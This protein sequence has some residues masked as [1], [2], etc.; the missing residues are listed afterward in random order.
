MGIFDRVGIRGLVPYDPGTEMGDAAS[1]VTPVEGVTPIGKRP[2]WLT[3]G[4]GAIPPGLEF[5]SQPTSLPYRPHAATALT[6]LAQGFLGVMSKANEAKIA[7]DERQQMHEE[8][9]TSARLQERSIIASETD[10]AR[11]AKIEEDRNNAIVRK[12]VID[13]VRETPGLSDFAARTGANVTGLLTRF[14]T[15][16]AT[17]EEENLVTQG[18]ASALKDNSLDPALKSAISMRIAAL[19]PDATPEQLTK[20]RVKTTEEYIATVGDPIKRLKAEQQTLKLQN[21]YIAAQTEN[22][23]GADMRTLAPILTDAIGRAQANLNSAAALALKDD[24]NAQGTLNDLLSL[25]DPA[26]AHAMSTLSAPRD[27]K[28]NP[29]HSMITNLDSAISEFKRLQ[30]AQDKVMSAMGQ[31]AGVDI[32]A[33]APRATVDNG[34]PPPPQNMKLAPSADEAAPYEPTKSPMS[35]LM[36]AGTKMIENYPNMTVQQLKG[37]QRLWNAFTGRTPEQKLASAQKIATDALTKPQAQRYI[38]ENLGDLRGP[39]GASLPFTN[40]EGKKVSWADLSSSERQ[41]ALV[42]LHQMS[43]DEE[44]HRFL[45][46]NMLPG[47]A[48]S[49]AIAAQPANAA[50]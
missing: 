14:Y 10:N 44:F 21:D 42:Q 6:G 24:T 40:S 20:L 8:R 4:L 46:F 25:S 43:G 23:Q 36:D 33:F 31:R 5:G 28:G 3:R 9:A 11:R 7:K 13:T 17:P 48:Y 37:A 12:N 22:L 16:K 15:G 18:F 2:G 34:N 29:D 30:A 26:R 32:P 47:D 19:G 27:A 50:P 45:L 1:V 35:K 39:D 49:K 38:A 41:A